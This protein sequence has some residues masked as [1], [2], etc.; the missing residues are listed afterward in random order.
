[1]RSLLV[2]CIGNPIAAYFLAANKNLDARRIDGH[3]APSH[4]RKNSSPIRIGARPRGLDQR[5]VRDGPRHQQSLFPSMRLLDEQTN[6]VLTP[7][8]SLTI[9]SASDWQTA[10][11]AADSLF[12]TPP[13]R[14]RTPLAPLASSRTVSL[15]E[16]SPSMDMQ[17]NES[18]HASRRSACSSRNSRLHP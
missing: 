6:D 2:K 1:M 8:P 3:A 9:C 15:V 16:V 12:P 5:G 17:L 14:A 11:K 13:S 18:S 7:S 4:C 10:F